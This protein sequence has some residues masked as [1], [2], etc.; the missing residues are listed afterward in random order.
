MKYIRLLL[1]FILFILFVPVA[2]LH[3]GVF[4]VHNFSQGDKLAFTITS[5]IFGQSST[6][7]IMEFSEIKEQINRIPKPLRSYVKMVVRNM[8]RPQKGLNF[9]ISSKKYRIVFKNDRDWKI[10]KKTLFKV[11]DYTSVS[12]KDKKSLTKN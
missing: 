1:F 4:R 7:P 11:L 8:P 6:D 10:F 5:E 9:T 12:K 2:L 3:S